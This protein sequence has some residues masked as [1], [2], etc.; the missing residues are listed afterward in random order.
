MMQ[1]KASD[2]PTCGE[3]MCCHQYVS[4]GKLMW[5]SYTC[6]TCIKLVADVKHSFHRS[7]SL[8]WICWNTK[9]GFKWPNTTCMTVTLTVFFLPKICK[10][11]QLRTFR[12]YPK[13]IHTSNTFINQIWQRDTW[14]KYTRRLTASTSVWLAQSLRH[15][16]STYHLADTYPAGCPSHPWR[17]P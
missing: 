8:H 15:Q 14:D 7:V 5:M 9:R 17:S 16:R 3:R 1:S 11:G 12:F 13:F 6:G 10:C 2:I 4:D